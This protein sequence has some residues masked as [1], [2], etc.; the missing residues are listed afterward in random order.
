M[1]KPPWMRTVA[2]RVFPEPACSTCCPAPASPAPNAPTQG[3]SP[4][5]GEV[6]SSAAQRAA[7][8]IDRQLS[9]WERLPGRIGK[10][11][12]AT[13]RAAMPARPRIGRQRPLEARADLALKHN[14]NTDK[15]WITGEIAVRDRV[16]DVSANDVSVSG[17]TLRVGEVSLYDRSGAK[18]GLGKEG[19]RDMVEVIRATKAWAR[20]QGF[21][22]LEASWERAGP[23]QSGSSANPG[24]QVFKV[25]KL[26]QPDED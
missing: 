3:L 23:D 19:A 1:D 17:G 26:T 24:K 14:P 7:E 25:Y 8:D 13:P 2:D 4:W 20:E 16:F 5:S 15:R 22:T 12:R 18:V 10:G 21:T 9:V 11:A 6:R